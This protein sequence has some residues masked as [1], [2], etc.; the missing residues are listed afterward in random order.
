MVTA[1]IL[2][3]RENSH[4]RAGNWIQD[5]MISQR[6]WP[7]DHEADR[8]NRCTSKVPFVTKTKYNDNT[9]LSVAHLLQWSVTVRQQNPWAQRRIRPVMAQNYKNF[10]RVETGVLTSRDTCAPSHS[11]YF[12]KGPVLECSLGML[13]WH[14]Q[15]CQFHNS[16]EVK[17]AIHERVQM[18][19]PDSC[20]DRTFQLCPW[21]NLSRNRWPPCRYSM[22]NA[23]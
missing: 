22:Q 14:L 4:G 9:A 19:E 20:R 11:A 8:I 16:E 13:T 21:K 3:F 5:L 10:I 12:C 15:G 7:L 6:L 1:G 23:K 2:P 17:M 18:P